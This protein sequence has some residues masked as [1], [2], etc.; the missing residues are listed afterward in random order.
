[1]TKAVDRLP[2]SEGY[3]YLAM[4]PNDIKGRPLEL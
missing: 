2:V 4:K 1:M 3:S